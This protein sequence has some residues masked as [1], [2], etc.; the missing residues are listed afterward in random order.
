MIKFFRNIR[1]NLLNEGK[2]SKYFKYAIGEIVLVVIGILI[3]LQINNWNEQRKKAQV[4]IYTLVDVKSDIQENVKNLEVGIVIL[5]EVY[6][7]NLKIIDY[8]QQKIPYNESMDTLFNNFYTNWDPDFTY[9]AFENLKNQG[10]SLISNEMLRKS[11]ITL[12]EVEMNILD[13]SELNRQDMI[14]ENMILPIQKKYFYRSISVDSEFWPLV[15]SD[16][17]NMIH[18]P[19]FYSACTEIAYRQTRSI[20]RFQEFNIKAKHVIEQIDSELENME[21]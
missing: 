3:A 19:E 20:A 11:L 13:V 7:K 8:Y 14:Y 4:E 18:D 9:A 12:H 21:H 16:Y 5:K 17:E 10:V 2:T 15:L 6:N 1:K